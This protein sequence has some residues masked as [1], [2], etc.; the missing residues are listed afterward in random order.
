[1]ADRVRLGVIGVGAMGKSHAARARAGEINR[2]ELVAV[3]DSD[4]TRLSTYDGIKTYTNSAELIRSGEVDAV[5]IATP[6]YD[7]TTVGIDAIQNGL[8]VL[9]EKPISAHKADCQRLIAAHDANKKLVFRIAPDLSA[10]T[11]PA[12][13]S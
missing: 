9:V 8:H 12:M 10:W 5:V 3:C 11:L 13:G 7:H 2:C 1:M 4:E 6:H